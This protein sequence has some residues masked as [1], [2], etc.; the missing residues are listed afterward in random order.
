[1]AKEGAKSKDPG[2]QQPGVQDAAHHQAHTADRT[3]QNGRRE[4]SQRWDGKIEGTVDQGESSPDH[5]L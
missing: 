1:M 4:Q 3:D 5:N 2:N